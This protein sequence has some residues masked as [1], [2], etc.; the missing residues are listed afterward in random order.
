MTPNPNGT[1]GS[2]K[3]NDDRSNLPLSSLQH[4]LLMVMVIMVIIA[5]ALP[6]TI[7]VHPKIQIQIQME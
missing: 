6:I 3:N 2:N 1:C 5:L 4:V 7:L